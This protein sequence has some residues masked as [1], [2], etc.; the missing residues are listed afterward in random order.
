MKPVDEDP[1]AGTIVQVIRLRPGKRTPLFRIPGNTHLAVLQGR[2][3]ITP[4]GG[5]T[6]TMRQN[7]YAYVPGGL[8]FSFANPRVYDGPEIGRAHV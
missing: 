4:A 8:A 1:A 7:W 5:S 2:V 3:E 6:S